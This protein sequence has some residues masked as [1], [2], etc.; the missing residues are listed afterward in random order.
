MLWRTTVSV[1]G[2][3]DVVET[4]PLT[5]GLP[6]EPAFEIDEYGDSGVLV[7]FTDP[8]RSA[9]W[10]RARRMAQQL[11]AMPPAG[12][13]DVLSSFDTLFVAFDPVR[14]DH[15]AISAALFARPAVAATGR[16][17]RRHLVPVVFGG[18]AGPDLDAVAAELQMS[19]GAVVE[20]YCEREWTVRVIGSPIGAPLL[21]RADLPHRI[22][23]VSRLRQPRTRLPSG[24]LGVSGHQ[25]VLYPLACPGGWQ[26]IG[27]T[28][29]RIV[30]VG[31][32]PRSELE[33]GDLVRYLPIRSGV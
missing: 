18:D 10:E 7:S 1:S 9:C 13:V 29:Q 28:A 33:P 30:Q 19:A 12:L 11:S 4:L 5:A 16:P 14:T 31:A 25:T 6:A 32:Q 27:R 8:D 20:L 23:S 24:S 22:V 15:A 17:P 2:R 21:D 26:L 3:S